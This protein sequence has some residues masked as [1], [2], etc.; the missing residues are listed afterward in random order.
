MRYRAK[1]SAFAKVAHKTGSRDMPQTKKVTV[2]IMRPK[3]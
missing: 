3:R 1:T 2:T